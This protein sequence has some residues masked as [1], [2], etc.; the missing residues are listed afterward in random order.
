MEDRQSFHDGTKQPLENAS[1]YEQIKD[2]LVTSG[3]PIEAVDIDVAD[4][5]KWLNEFSQVKKFY[6]SMG[7][8]CVE[9]CLEHY[10]AYRYLD[11]TPEDVYIDI[12]SAGSPWANILSKRHIR[13]FRLDMVFPEGLHGNDIGADAGNTGLP[14]DHATALSAQCAYECFMGDSDVRFVQEAGRILRSKGRLVIVPLYLDD[15][16]FVATSPFCDQREV[17]I[18]QKAKRVWRDDEYKVPFS[19]HYSPESFA[20]RIYRNLPEGLEGKVFYFRNVPQVINHFPG[21]RVYCYF[22]FFGWKG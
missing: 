11:L 4:F 14:D 12:A 8:V 17:V 15:T 21:Q 7:D 13:S 5:E 1:Q 18:D 6:R 16:Y 2:R 20:E 9:K 3:V 19:R 10:L 22:L